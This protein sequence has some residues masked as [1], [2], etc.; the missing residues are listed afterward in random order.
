M[1]EKSRG[2]SDLILQEL[3]LQLEA[4]ANELKGEVMIFELA[5]HVQ[6]FLHEHNK[7]TYKSFYEEMMSR[8]LEQQQLQQQAKQLEEDREVFITLQ[9]N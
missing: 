4:K 6:S 3:K 2:M 5:Q 1:L 8:Q 9:V 7:P